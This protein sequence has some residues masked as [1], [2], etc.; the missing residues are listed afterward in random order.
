MLAAA[1]RRIDVGDRRRIG[2][3]PRVDRRARW[4]TDSQSWSCRAR[5]RVPDN[6]SRRRTAWS[7]SSGAAIS[8]SCRGRSSNA[9]KPTQCASVERSICT[10]SRA[11]ICACRYSGRCSAYLE[12]THVGDESPRSAIRLRSIA[13]VPAPGS[14]RRPIGAGLLTASGRHISVAASRSPGTWPGSCRAVPSDPRRSTCR[15]PPQH[16]HAL[17]VGFDDDLLA[18]QVRRQMAA[19]GTALLCARR[20]SAIALA[21]SACGLFGERCVV[22]TSSSARFELIVADPLR[23]RPK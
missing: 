21:F 4:P 5:D 10:P 14:R 22:S 17:L 8:R 16:G 1:S 6:A 18:R 12:T 13:P 2:C 19:I 23:L 7:T 15:S 20:A 11:R 9:A 3:R